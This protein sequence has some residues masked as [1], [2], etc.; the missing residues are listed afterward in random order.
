MDP[1]SS[2]SVAAAAAADDEIV[3]STM[4]TPRLVFELHEPGLVTVRCLTL[5]S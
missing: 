3:V 1:A 2:D 4:P 5:K